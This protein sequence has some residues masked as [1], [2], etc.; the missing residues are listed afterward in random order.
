MSTGN[1]WREIKSKLDRILSNQVIVNASEFVNDVG[2][3]TGCFGGSRIHGR[4]T[5]I[6]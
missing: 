3:G 4:R 6:Y 1:I 2:S 5:H